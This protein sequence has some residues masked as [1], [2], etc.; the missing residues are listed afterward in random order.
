MKVCHC[1]TSC[2]DLA[3]GEHVVAGETWR[4]DVGGK[5]REVDYSKPSSD[6]YNVTSPESIAYTIPA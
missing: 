3:V 4:Q 1:V 6:S 5:I 2:H